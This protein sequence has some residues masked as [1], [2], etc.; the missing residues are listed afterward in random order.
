MLGELISIAA[1]VDRP[2]SISVDNILLHSD[3][4]QPAGRE[5]LKVRASRRDGQREFCTYS[6]GGP[7]PIRHLQTEQ[8]LE[9]FN[10][11]DTAVQKCAEFR[12]DAVW[13]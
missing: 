11:I 6:S 10:G 7:G 9:L 1:Q 13:R 5:R 2:R 3:L 12:V 4:E 8:N